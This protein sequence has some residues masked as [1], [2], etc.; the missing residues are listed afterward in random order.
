MPTSLIMIAK[1]KDCGQPPPHYENA[2][3]GN[4]TYLDGVASIRFCPMRF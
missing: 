3:K 4:I 1:T 2:D